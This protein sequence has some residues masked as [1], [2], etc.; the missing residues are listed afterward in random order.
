MLYRIPLF[1]HRKSNHIFTVWQHI[2][3]LVIRQY[4]AKSYR[5]FVDWLVEAYYLRIVLQLSH[6]PHF[7]T[8]QKFTERISGT[9]LGKI[10]SSF[11]ILTKIGQLF[12]GIDSSG[13]KAT[14]ASQYY[15]ERAKL[16]RRRKYIKLS[17]TADLVQQTICTIKIRRAPTRHDTIDFQPL[18]TKTSEILPLSLVIG[19]KG[20]DS[21]DNHVLVR[22]I[23]DGFSVIPA[24]YEQVPIRRTHGRYRK[25]MKHGYSQLL[26][27]QRNKDE[28]IFSVIK[29]LF[30]EH[31][32]SRLVS[33]QNRELSLRCIAY[34]LH[35]LTN[36][37]II[38]MV[39]TEP[40]CLSTYYNIHKKPL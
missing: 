14:H 28:T 30:G 22:D 19:D 18:I 2:V 3:L 16:T 26:Y 35:R 38:L 39:S 8:L 17:L 10:I 36:L 27:S 34:N 15:T 9:L 23:L 29:R 1:L 13:F 40:R 24:R 31:I 21:E 32:T 11:I 20:Y 6:I 7:T 37:I 12:I 25:Q 4:E 5:L 33:T